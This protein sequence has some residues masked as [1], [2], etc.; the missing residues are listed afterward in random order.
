MKASSI[1]V[2]AAAAAL[3]LVLAHEADVSMAASAV[4]CKPTELNPCIGAITSG[5][6]PSPLC[7]TKM[8][9]QSPCFCQYIKNPDYKKIVTSPNAKKVVTACGVSIP[10]C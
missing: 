2:L 6:R 4:T 7:C 9:Q 8:K 10:K 1:L 3:V 5:A